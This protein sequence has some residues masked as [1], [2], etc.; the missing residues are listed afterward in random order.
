MKK[1]LLLA[2]VPLALS[3]CGTTTSQRALGGAAIG[4]GAGAVAGPIGVGT[5][6]VIGGAV[7]VV[8]PSDKVNLG[9]PVW[10]RK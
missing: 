10:D 2:L 7:G 3:A 8:T 5:G 9:K 6:A 1:F 4:A